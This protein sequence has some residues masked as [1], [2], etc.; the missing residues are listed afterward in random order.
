[1]TKKGHQKLCEID[2]NF[3][4]NAEIFWENFGKNLF[5]PFLKFLIR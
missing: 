4:G 2:E 1:M 3:L 5:P